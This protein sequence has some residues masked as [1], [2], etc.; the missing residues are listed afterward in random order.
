MQV[1]AIFVHHMASS[2][3]PFWVHRNILCHGIW[4][5][6]AVDGHCTYCIGASRD[7]TCLFCYGSDLKQKWIIFVEKLNRRK[8]KLLLTY[9]SAFASEDSPVR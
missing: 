7:V 6:L 4:H 2:Q 8:W 9:P 5:L 3:I 1:R